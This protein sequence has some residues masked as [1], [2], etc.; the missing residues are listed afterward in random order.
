M[1]LPVWIAQAAADDLE[2]IW[3]YVAQRNFDAADTL[4]DLL[5]ATIVRLGEW[6]E[7]GRARPELEPGLRSFPVDSYV[8]YYRAT[9]R[10]VEVARVLHARRDVDAEL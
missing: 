1:P 10:Q 8:V 9:D 5:G 2:E 7:M 3:V 6:P 4:I